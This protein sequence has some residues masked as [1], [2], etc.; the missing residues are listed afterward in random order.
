MSSILP[1]IFHFYVTV[2]VIFN[3]ILKQLEFFIDGISIMIN[4]IFRLKKTLTTYNSNVFIMT[5]IMLLI[6]VMYTTSN[7][8]FWSSTI[9]II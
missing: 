8:C 2:G 6:S 4:Q 3:E 7:R 5:T 9:D 1:E